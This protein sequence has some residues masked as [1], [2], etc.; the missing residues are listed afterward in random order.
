MKPLDPKTEP[1][2][3]GMPLMSLKEELIIQQYLEYYN[4][5]RIL[6]YG[7]GNSTKAFSKH[8]FIEE[9]VGVEHNKEWVDQVASWHL[10][11]VKLLWHPLSDAEHPYACDLMTK[12]YATKD[13]VGKFDFVFID[14]D[15]RC[16][17]LQFAPE[18]LS[19][20]GFAMLHDAS[21]PSHWPACKQYWKHQVFLTPGAVCGVSGLPH[22]GLC[23]L[24]NDDRDLV[25]DKKEAEPLV[26]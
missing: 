15:Y 11:K 21:R 22:Q 3:Y 13:L 2:R 16:Q 1:I 26:I 14:G 9:Y 7:I 23:L 8:P 19:P 6:E 25:L 24:W 10:P 5:R 12:A 20:T 4:P 17:C 18:L